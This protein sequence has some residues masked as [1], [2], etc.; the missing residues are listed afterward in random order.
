MKN[1]Q[2]PVMI[3][4]EDGEKEVSLKDKGVEFCGPK[5]LLKKT[6]ISASLDHNDAYNPMFEEEVEKETAKT[7]QV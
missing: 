5:T 3:K 1:T 4:I 6:A 7:G 2:D